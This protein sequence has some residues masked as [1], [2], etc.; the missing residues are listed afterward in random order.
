MA[1]ESSFPKA[2]LAA[3]ATLLLVQAVYHMRV[4]IQ[5]HH[6]KKSSQ[7]L[8]KQCMEWGGGGLIWLGWWEC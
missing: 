6:N 7:N 5:S 2:D 3:V 8:E 1:D 4:V